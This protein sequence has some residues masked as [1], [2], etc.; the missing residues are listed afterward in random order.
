MTFLAKGVEKS[1]TL[2]NKIV[3]GAWLRDIRA[4]RPV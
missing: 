3:V 4:E 1:L 2:D